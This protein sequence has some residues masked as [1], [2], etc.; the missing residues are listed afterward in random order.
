MK[1]YDNIDK[2]RALYLINYIDG[3]FEHLSIDL[4]NDKQL[5]LIAVKKKG[6]QLEFA[7]EELK[8]DKEVVSFAIQSEIGS[9]K[10]ANDSLKSDRSFIM[11]QIELPGDQMGLVFLNVSEEL[12]DDKE[13]ALKAIKRNYTAFGW[14]SENLRND[15]EFVISAMKVN[16][17]SLLQA[18]HL[19]KDIE[20]QAVAVKQDPSAYVATTDE[21]KKDEEILKSVLSQKGRMLQYALP[22]YKEDKEIVLIALQNDMKARMFIGKNLKEEIGDENPLQYLKSEKSYNEI[23]EVIA[24]KKD[25]VK[26]PKKKI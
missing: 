26:K 17:Y 9:F 11:E 20:V 12:R 3:I 8:K 21:L 13:L 23:I 2:E 22:E 19:K 15:K 24:E 6:K 5:A 18:G 4:R 14:T 16:G 1:N 10:F 25:S 7:S